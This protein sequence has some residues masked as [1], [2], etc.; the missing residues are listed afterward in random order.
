MKYIDSIR[1]CLQVLP[2]R[3]RTKYFQTIIIQVFLSFLDL[4]GIAIIGVIGLIAIKGVQSQA[5]EGVALNFLNFFK[6]TNYAFQIQV[7][8]LAAIAAIALIMRTLFSLYFNWK[9]ISFLA[10]QST[11]ISNDLISRI[12]AKGS[13]EFRHRN[14]SEIQQILGPGVHAI[15]VGVLGTISSMLSDF[16]SFILISVAIILIDPIVGAISISL[17]LVIGFLLHFGLRRKIESYGK[18]FTDMSIQSSKTILDLVFGYRQIYLGNRVGYYLNKIAESKAKTARLYARNAF[19]PGLG[20]YLIEITIVLGGLFIAAALF[21]FSDS[22]RAFAGLGIFLTSGIRIA[23]AL[24]RIQQS[25]LSIKSNLGIAY[26]TID[27]IKNFQNEPLLL[28]SL[29]ETDFQHLT[30]KPEISVSDVRFKYNEMER[31]ELTIKGLKINEGEFVAIVGPSGGGKTTFVDIILGLLTPESGEILISGVPASKAM[32]NWPGA[33]AYVPQDVFVKEG[34]VKENVGLGYDPEIISAGFVKEALHIAQ[35]SGFVESLP[36]G[37]ETVVS[38]RGTSLSGGQRQRLGIARALYSKPKLLVLDEATSALDGQ[39]EE[40][41][42][43]AIST[44]LFNT[45]RIV[46]AHRLSTVQ[47]ADRVLYVSDGEIIAEGTFA[48]VRAT[49]PNFDKSAGLMGL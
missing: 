37:I 25:V 8:I 33:M 2:K 45:T 13:M 4:L 15:S 9:I 27:L 11:T 21:V 32:T 36:L 10:N 40:N 39:A 22:A 7:A 41:L 6:L 12:F 19:V 23:P 16:S 28:S 47:F 48:E 38:E 42:A 44:T 3:E 43:L 5:T 18:D 31:F 46:I 24:L 17:F 29:K 35:L 34:S 26:L 14:I 20:K 1:N 30:F 49:V